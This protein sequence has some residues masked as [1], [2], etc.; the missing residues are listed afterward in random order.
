VSSEKLIKNQKNKGDNSMKTIFIT[1]AT[2][3]TGYAI[4][5]HFAKNHF[6]V[7][8]SSRVREKAEAAARKI[9]EDFGVQA[10]G[11]ELDLTDTD[12]ISDVFSRIKKDFGTLDVFV[13][14][15]AH[16]GVGYGIFN[17]TPEIFDEITR[18]NERGTF[19]CCQNAAKIMKEQRSGNIVI[20]GSIQYTGAVRGRTVYSMT[21]GALASL[22]R[23]LAYELAEYNIRVNYIVAG[24]I[25]TNRWDNSPDDVVMKRRSQYPLGREASGEDIANAVYYL[26]TDLSSNITGIDLVIDAGLSVCLLPYKKAGEE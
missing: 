20:M 10:R 6:N 19:F 24:A 13:P 18:V 17:T 16:L 3:N 1:G 11:Y 15:S 8:I 4:A 7:A 21:K 12:N 23:N 22:T 2:E 5:R 9:E 14:N 26:A 25:H